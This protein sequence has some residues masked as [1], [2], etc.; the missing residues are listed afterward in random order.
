MRPF[1]IYSARDL[2]NLSSEI[3]RQAETGHIGL[4]TRHGKPCLLTIPFDET[5]LALGLHRSLAVHLF[6]SGE[7]TMAQAARLANM[8]IERFIAL[9]GEAGIDA[10]E[11]SPEEIETELQHAL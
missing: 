10:V 9:L 4:I 2:R 8:P 6:S 5:V 11:Y 3:I 1:D 7:L